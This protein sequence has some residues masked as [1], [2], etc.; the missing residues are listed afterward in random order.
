MQ[1]SQAGE[2]EAFC[3]LVNEIGPVI[4]RFLRRR[5]ADEHELDDVC[6][7]TLLAIYE[8]RHTYEPSRPFEP[9]MFAIARHVGAAHFKRYASR[10]SWQKIVDELPEK[11]ARDL[12]NLR[13]RFQEAM[14]QL[15]EIQR[16][17]LVMM[18]VNGFSLQ[19]ASEQ[20]GSSVGALKVRVHRA[21]EA[22]RKNLLG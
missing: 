1:R 19:E 8:S 17:A 20:T 18:K 21:Y 7:E 4:A 22:L 13:L 3:E 15:P 5:V 6:Q 16:E 11:A 14:A 12:G 2:R 9:W 10:T